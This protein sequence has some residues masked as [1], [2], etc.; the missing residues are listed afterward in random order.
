MKEVQNRMS[1]PITR[2]S[3]PVDRVAVQPPPEMVIKCPHCGA[4]KIKGWRV[5]GGRPG[6]GHRK[7]CTSC[8]LIY[9]M[10]ADGRTMRLI[11]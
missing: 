11:R 7:C 8:G 1:T 6:G 9:D 3:S 5:L 2:L 10:S 4:A